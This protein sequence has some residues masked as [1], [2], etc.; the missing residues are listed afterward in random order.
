MVDLVGTVIT[1]ATVGVMLAIY[2][3]MLVRLAAEMG[4]L[5]RRHA[6]HRRNGQRGW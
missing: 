4:R 1:L 5:E 6:H 3:V 2:C